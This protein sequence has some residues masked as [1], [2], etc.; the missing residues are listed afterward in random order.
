MYTQ[1][2][3]NYPKRTLLASRQK[4][5]CRQARLAHLMDCFTKSDDGDDVMMM[6]IVMMMMMMMMMMMTMM[7]LTLWG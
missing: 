1:S 4:E 3:V 2:K 6:M 5:L 7:I